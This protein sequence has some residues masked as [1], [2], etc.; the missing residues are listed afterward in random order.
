MDSETLQLKP[1]NGKRRMLVCFAHPDDESFGPGGTLAHYARAGV[2]VHLICA[3]R[4]EVGTIDQEYLNEYGSP[5]ALRSAELECA[6]R[7]LGLTA[8]YYL[9]YRDSGM[10]GSPDNEHPRA[11]AVAP[12]EELAARVAQLIRA[13]QPQVVLTFDPIGSYRHPD[14]IAMHAGTVAACDLAGDETY[15]SNALAPYTPQKLY[16]STFSRRWMRVLLKLMPL[17][18]QNPRT[19]GRNR[20]IDLVALTEIDF[21]LHAN[22]NISA[23]LAIKRAASACHRSQ[24]SFGT[25]RLVRMLFRRRQTRETFMRAK[26]EA[27]RSLREKDLFEGVEV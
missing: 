16:F 15:H 23:E 7:T 17:L 19:F 25:N 13:V 18:G 11:L 27:P 3:T 10:P 24:Q 9:G 5:A 6:A 8:V 22:I 4:G 20:D 12:V 14:H 21:P 2:D 26:P 1:A